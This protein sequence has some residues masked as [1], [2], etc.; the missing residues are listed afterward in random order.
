MDPYGYTRRIQIS[1]KSSQIPK[2]LVQFIRQR[3]RYPR[4]KG[5]N[6]IQAY[7]RARLRQLELDHEKIWEREEVP[8]C[9]KALLY[10]YYGLC[11]CI[12]ILYEDNP[13][14][15][16]WFLE[17]VARMPYFSYVSVLHFYETMGWWSIDDTLREEHNKEDMVEGKHLMIMEALGGGSK[18]RDRFLARHTAIAYY[19]VLLALY[20]L[21]PK[22]AYK[23]SEMLE[24]H[25]VNTYTEFLC[26]NKELLENLP[27]PDV[28]QKHYGPSV[29]NMYQIFWLIA[30]DERKHATSMSDL[31]S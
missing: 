7:N 23:S 2:P 16:F 20:F 19:V 12:D 27:I 5:N 4:V 26:Q 11:G 30:S 22:T 6:S 21:S 24:L 13:I 17:V 10:T 31:T 8:E 9:P 18:W 25:A 14:D 29:Y 28:A 15:R 1:R 3:A